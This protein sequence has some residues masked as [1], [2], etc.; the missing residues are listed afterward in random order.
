MAETMSYTT[1]IDDLR[2]YLERGGVLDPDVEAQLPRFVMLCEQKISTSLKPQGFERWTII[3]G[4]TA[5]TYVIPKPDRWHK[6][7]ACLYGLSEGTLR[8]PVL[9]RQK[10]FIETVYPDLA[11][12]GPPAHYADFGP[13]HWLFGPVMD[14]PYILN[15]GYY[16]RL[17]PLDA[18]NQTNWLTT[19]APQLL[20]YGSLLEAAP[21]LK[22]DERVPTWEQFYAKA[23]KALMGE[24]FSKPFDRMN[25]TEGR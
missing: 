25:T 10:E 22:N 21:Y 13:A 20:L 12:Q 15:M 16:E 6:N 24:D 7:I 23:E 14:M 18:A 5:G 2:S 3:S 17:N 9:L 19:Y 4:L 1:L 8:T 11:V